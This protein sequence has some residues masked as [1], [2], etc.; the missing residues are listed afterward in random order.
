[1][2]K[3]NTKQPKSIRILTVNIAT[4]SINDPYKTYQLFQFL[5]QNNIDIACINETNMNFAN[6]HNTK[7]IKK[8]AHRA[9]RNAFISFSSIPNTVKNNNT[10]KPPLHQ[11]GGVMIVLAP[12]ITSHKIASGRDP[13][14]RWTWI[15]LENKKGKKK[16][17]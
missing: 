17:Q 16:Q 10:T 4:L 9:W 14:G 3:I 12:K 6:Y 1:M 2:K 8:M 15:E 5:K 11:Q 13:S 7:S